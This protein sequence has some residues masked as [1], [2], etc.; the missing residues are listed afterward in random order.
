MNGSTSSFSLNSSTV[1]NTVNFINSALFSF[2][3]MIIVN[4]TELI[5]LD[6]SRC[7][8]MHSFLNAKQCSDDD[9]MGK[10]PVVRTEYCAVY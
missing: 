10:Q 5:P 7:D 6:D 9:Y 2:R 3:G 8:R 1:S 4:A